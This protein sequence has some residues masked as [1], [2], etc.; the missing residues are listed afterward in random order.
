MLQAEKLELVKE[1]K[2]LKETVT[3][4]L[5][6][7]NNSRGIVKK[8]N[9]E[10]IT[11]SSEQRI[12]EDQ[13][14]LLEAISIG[15]QLVLDE[16]RTLDLL[17]KNKKLLEPSTPIEPDYTKVPEG[18]TESDLLRI[19]GNSESTDQTKSNHRTKTSKKNSMA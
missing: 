11:L 10:R 8:S 2:A 13:I 12:I 14:T 18:Q 16:V 15:R 17:I 4:L 19:A 3:K 1:N 7:L 6:E 5:E 9:V